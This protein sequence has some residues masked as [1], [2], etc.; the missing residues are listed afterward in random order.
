MVG[1]IASILKE[2]GN[3]HRLKY[4]ILKCNGGCSPQSLSDLYRSKG[5]LTV[6]DFYMEALYVSFN[7]RF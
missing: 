1:V 4:S 2:K 7:L 5:L 6:S 3:Y